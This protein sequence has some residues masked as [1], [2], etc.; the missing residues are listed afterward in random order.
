[1][2]H[3]DI[4]ALDPDVGG[5]DAVAGGG[6]TR[7]APVADIGVIEIATA[8][9]GKVEVAPVAGGRRGGRAVAVGVAAGGVVLDGGEGDPA[10]GG[11]VGVQGAG[12][13][14]LGLLGRELDHRPSLYRQSNARADRDRAAHDVRT[15]HR[16]PSRI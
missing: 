4:A 2:I 12:D 10:R 1:M 7:V 5:A 3:V 14:D 13:G 9:R 8:S 11:A 6:A 16:R 15:V